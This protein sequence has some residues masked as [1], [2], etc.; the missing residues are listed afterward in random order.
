LNWVATARASPKT[1]KKERGKK[2]RQE[3][4]KNQAGDFDV[5]RGYTSRVEKKQGRK[6]KRPLNTGR[7]PK[8]KDQPSKKGGNRRSY[9]TPA[10]ECPK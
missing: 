5:D 2:K 4:K 8:K 6:K 3:R 9:T 7:K 10:Q 1:G